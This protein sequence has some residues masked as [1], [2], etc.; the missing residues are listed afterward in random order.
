MPFQLTFENRYSYADLDA[1]IEISAA[2]G[3]Q[4]RVIHTVAKVDPGAEVC[5]FSNDIGIRLGLKVEEG[6]PITLDS[7]GGPVEAFGHE[8]WLQ[9][10]NLAFTSF[11]Y[12]AKYPGL[13]RNLLGRQGWLRQL[14]IAIVDYD[15]LLYLSRYDE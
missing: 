7:L 13:R 3:H 11:V 15:N 12:F 14:R 9:T 4:G 6:I 2:L 8:V 1:G 5:L 10:C